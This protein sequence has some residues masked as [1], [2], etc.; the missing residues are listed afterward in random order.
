MQG[1]ATAASP[2]PDAYRAAL[3][4]LRPALALAALFSALVNI[5]MLTGSVYMLQVYDRVLASGSLPTLL[6]L[7]AIVVVLHGFLGQYDF[8]RTR[9][10]ARAGIRLD[11][12]V[13]AAGFRAWIG[14][15][16]GAEQPLRELDTLRGFLAGPAVIGLFDLPWMPLYLALLFLIHPWLGWTT[17]AGAAVVVVLALANQRLNRGPIA[18]AM[19]LEAEE[20]DFAG[21]CRRMRGTLGAMGMTA[22]V[23]QE[24]QRRHEA[25][26]A[27]GQAGSDP[28][29][30]LAAVSHAFRLLLQST[31]LTIGAWLVL[32][33]EITA[34]MI[35][36]ASIIAGRALAPID[37]VVGQWR[38][39]GRA[40]EAHRRLAGLF[41]RQPAP[42]AA[43][44]LPPPTGRI[45]VTGLTKH[46]PLPA[47]SGGTAGGTAGGARRAILENL[48]FELAP[49]DGLVVLGSSAA[50]KST[51][52]R[53]LVGAAAAD[54]GEIRFDGA[55][56]DQ[57]RPQDLGRWIG[58]LP[59]TVEMLPGTIR[60]NIARFDPGAAD[61]AVIEAA[62]LT[63]VHEMILAL[64]EGYA[65]RLGAEDSPLSG[66]QIQRLGLTRAVF[67]A[68][69]IVVLDEPDAHLDPAGEAALATVITSLRA[70]G[71][72]VIVMAHRP[73]VLA[74]A[75]RRMLLEAGRLQ[76]FDS[77][78]AAGTA[79]AAAAATAG[80][81][82]GTAAAADL[83][84]QVAER[85]AQVARL[86]AALREA[87]PR[88]ALRRHPLAARG[89]GSPA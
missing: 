68:P 6:G 28:S 66:G 43:L 42:A 89:T 14:R 19:A 32:G 29:E 56:P 35:V 75:N 85:L 57:W 26:L 20:R 67:G 5:L 84:P 33:A 10:L 15:D 31:I 39:I 16:A 79:A 1:S 58:Y 62:R 40:A 60:D 45:R 44:A 69:R 9:L 34:G 24:W 3:A 38:M 87:G 25:A 7:F 77:L 18:R 65:T 36:A 27:A 83:P 73:G 48:S 71:A 55:T 64:P 59:Q 2:P 30:A 80:I 21:Q 78:P 49:G 53:L 76:R 47:G 88:A 11:R 54:A 8:L 61:A 17:L 23:S 82:P 46:A 50:G 63:G 22:R 81:A 52:A 70:R 13:G 41:A 4:G 72:V 37:R 86:S 51:L 12:A 74:A